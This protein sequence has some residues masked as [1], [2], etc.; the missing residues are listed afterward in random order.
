MIW[1]PELD[2]PVIRALD[3]IPI[4]QDGETIF[5]LRD[6]LGL[7]QEG[8][9]VPL[10]TY[11][12]M[13]L[14]SGEL[15]LDEIAQVFKARFG[16]EVPEG[17]LQEIILKLD[18]AHCLETSAFRRHVQECL[19]AFRALP[20][21]PM[22]HA[23]TGYPES[24]D[25]FRAF[26]DAQWSCEGGPGTPPVPRSGATVRAI[27]A[28]H[29]DF[30]RGAVNYA[31]AY[32][33]LAESEPPQT[34][35]AL[36]TAHALSRR[37][38]TGTR[39]PHD[40]PLGPLA[41]DSEFLD[42]LQSRVDHD[43]REEEILHLSEHSVEFQAVALRHIFADVEDLRIVPLICGPLNGHR[44]GCSET[45]PS[46]EFER[47]AGALV[48]TIR[49][50]PRRIAVVAGAD[51]AHV[52]PNFGDEGLTT[53]AMMAEVRAQD[54]EAI[55]RIEAGDAEGFLQTFAPTANARR[56]CS[57]ACL[58]TLLRCLPALGVESGRLLNYTQSVHP[59]QQLAVTHASLVFPS[60]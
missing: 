27:V 14:M 32:R 56:V 25:E 3:P 13:T 38:F 7:V 15:T 6:P 33:A 45:R 1:Y 50:S 54:A 36:G 43:L 34:V 39:L 20:S 18:A 31:W 35:I 26:F 12:L 52:G 24:A 9:A 44:D 4:E 55:R 5:L 40:T 19:D 8:V 47:A 60:S 11:L 46:D 29:I 28:P 59:S 49:S 30:Q 41:V 2:R 42:D 37:P 10:P 22:A 51:L 48:E 21:R 17:L 23:G 57:V 53:E 58:Y 16:H